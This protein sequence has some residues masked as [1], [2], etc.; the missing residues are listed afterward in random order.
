M[1]NWQSGQLCFF[2]KEV[3]V[4]A[5]LVRIQHSPQHANMAEWSIAT[6]CKRVAF[7]LRRFESFYSHNMPGVLG[8][9]EPPKLVLLSSIL[10]LGAKIY[11][12]WVWGCCTLRCQ[13]RGFVGSSPTGRATIKYASVVQRTEQWVSTSQIWVQFLVGVLRKNMGMIWLR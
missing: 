6:R 5:P 8:T 7:G 3:S 1:E 4:I 12:S 11:P 9:D 13:R 10:R 2:A